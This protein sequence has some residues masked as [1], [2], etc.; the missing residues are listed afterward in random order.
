MCVGAPATPRA[1]P[2]GTRNAVRDPDA[3]GSRTTC[4]VLDG[5]AVEPMVGFEPTTC[6]LRNRLRSSGQV[7]R[8][9]FG[10]SPMT[11]AGSVPIAEFSPVLV[12]VG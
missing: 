3:H 5:L 7:H 9:P 2:N 4:A 12:S 6:R 1:T 8:V 10:A 11:P